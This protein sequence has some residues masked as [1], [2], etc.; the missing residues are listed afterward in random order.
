[1]QAAIKQVSVAQDRVTDAYIREVMDLDRYEVEMEKLRQTRDE[2][3]RATRALDQR[4]QQQEDSVRALEHL[5]KF[6]NRVSRGLDALSLRQQLLQLVVEG[7]TVDNGRVRVETIIP[8]GDSNLRNA[9]GEI[10]EPPTVRLRQSQGERIGVMA[11][12]ESRS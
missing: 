2:L 5:D 12:S 8:G 3:E 1:M 10:V 7:V 6:C 11:F 4:Q 9:C